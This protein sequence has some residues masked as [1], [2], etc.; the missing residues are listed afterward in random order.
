MVGGGRCGDE[1]ET[2]VAEEEEMTVGDS[3]VVDIE[4][5]LLRSH[6]DLSCT[7]LYFRPA[8]GFLHNGALVFGSGSRDGSV[9]SSGL[10]V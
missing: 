6:L 4:V 10:L 3:E 1:E 9:T 8:G 5:I 2:R 7:V